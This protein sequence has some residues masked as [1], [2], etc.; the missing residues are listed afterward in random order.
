[1]NY[2]FNITPINRVLHKA[3]SIRFAF[4]HSVIVTQDIINK[5][6]IEV[7]DPKTGNTVVYILKPDEEHKPL[8]LSFLLRDKIIVSCQHLTSGVIVGVYR[9]TLERISL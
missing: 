4:L 3:P 5:G 9:K 1:M 6:Y 8:P 7:E 2:L